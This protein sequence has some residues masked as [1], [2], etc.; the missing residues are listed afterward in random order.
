MT[1]YDNHIKHKI[2]A[3]LNNYNDENVVYSNELLKY[4][5]LLSYKKYKS[6]DDEY[7][8][9]I[10]SEIMDICCNTREYI[11][12]LREEYKLRLTET[13]IDPKLLVLE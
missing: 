2:N 6:Y 11:E 5:V 3:L 13:T 9:S 7:S 4:V 1:A 8:P 10:Y 12:Y